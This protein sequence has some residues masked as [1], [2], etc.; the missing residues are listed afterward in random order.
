MYG[1]PQGLP[2]K[3]VN[4][5]RWGLPV[6]RA[7]AGMGPAVHMPLPHRLRGKQGPCVR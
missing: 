2:R 7:V 1:P 3:W 5:M 6:P 4:G